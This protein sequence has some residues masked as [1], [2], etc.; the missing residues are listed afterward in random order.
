MKHS[1][2]T[3]TEWLDFLENRH[4]QEIQL[5]LARIKKV[6]ES[7]DLLSPQAKVITVAGTNGKGSTVATLEA[8]YSA[9]GYQVASY[10]SPHLLKFNERIQI[11]KKLISDNDLCKAFSL[12]EESRGEVPL[13]YFEM[14][15]LAALWYFKQ[16]TLDL[17]I[18]E[19]GLGGRLDATNIIDSDLAIITTIDL[20]HQDYLGNTKE[21]I[22]FEKAGILRPKCLF[23]YADKNP[24]AS[25]IDQAI[26]LETSSFIQGRDYEFSLGENSIELHFQGER[27]ELPKPKLHPNSVVA[28]IIA[29]ILL[30]EG[31][32]L[33]HAHW[34]QGLQTLSLAGRLQVVNSKRMTLFDVAHNPQAVRH[35]AEYLGNHYPQKRI[36]AVFSALKDKDIPGLIAPLLSCVTNWY[37]ALL[38]TK[39]AA[40][41]EQF[42]K[43]FDQF[44]I[45]T[46]CYDNP[47]LAYQSACEEASMDD[48][49]VVYGSFIT[50]S[51]LILVG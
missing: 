36:H 6:A 10:T 8:I 29:S 40:S 9:A 3:L 5:G 1:D 51:D 30:G 27:T 48:L 22:G 28:A 41:K 23:V 26:S 46:S 38:E 45:N 16:H 14:A 7:L 4:Q 13:T 34:Q 19:V 31:L 2:F 43:A 32:P 20:D 44:G 18:L 21:E 49:I 33:T 17:I 37:P 50:V 42:I 47:L 24:T 39:R 35:L 12:I 11:N 15:T 25:I